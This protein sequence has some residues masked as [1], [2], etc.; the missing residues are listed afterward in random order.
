MQQDVVCHAVAAQQ[1][2]PSRARSLLF[3]HARSLLQVRRLYSM[4]MRYCL[5]PSSA[6]R[7]ALSAW[8]VFELNMRATVTVRVL[9][10]QANP[11][12]PLG[13]PEVM[14]WSRHGLRSMELGPLGHFGAVSSA[15]CCAA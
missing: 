6:G 14:H 15:V 5:Q 11:G 12:A 10:S 9:V 7:N 13:L 3:R 4:S 1:D 2:A 8:L